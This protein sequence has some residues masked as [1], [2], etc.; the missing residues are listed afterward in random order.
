MGEYS[1]SGPMIM[2]SDVLE[3]I[4]L[5]AIIREIDLVKSLLLTDT[6]V[7]QLWGIWMENTTGWGL[8]SP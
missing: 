8:N 3:W 5:A 2:S 4:S 6:F 7:F 1:N